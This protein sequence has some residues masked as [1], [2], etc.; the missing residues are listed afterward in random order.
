M[1]KYHGE[2][3]ATWT[4][5]SLVCPN[6]TTQGRSTLKRL[7]CR[8]SLFL[9]WRD[10][11]LALFGPNTFCTG[12]QKDYCCSSEG[13]VSGRQVGQPVLWLKWE[14]KQHCSSAW[15]HA[16]IPSVPP[17]T[18]P[19]H[20]LKM[21]RCLCSNCAFGGKRSQVGGLIKKQSLVYQQSTRSSN[22][23][24]TQPQLCCLAVSCKSD[25]V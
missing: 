15:H 14:R 5:R 1:R 8:S 13:R 22:L 18:G 2:R 21:H 6:S 23:Y 12:G 16:M 17:Q 25:A 4:A 19:T 9:T 24:P 11:L 10:S 7:C 3:L 20:L